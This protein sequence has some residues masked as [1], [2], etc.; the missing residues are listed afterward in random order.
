MDPSDFSLQEKAKKKFG[1]FPYEL[2]PTKDY[3][4]TLYRFYCEEQEKCE[5]FSELKVNEIKNLG[6]MI[7]F[8]N[9][10]TCIQGRKFIRDWLKN[11]N[12][13][14]E[15]NF[16]QEWVLWKRNPVE[17]VRA[18]GEIEKIY[19]QS[20]QGI[21]HLLTREQMEEKLKNIFDM[22][23]ELMKHKEE[24]VEEP[25]HPAR[26]FQY[27]LECQVQMKKLKKSLKKTNHPLA[28][29]FQDTLYG[30]YLFTLDEIFPIE[31]KKNFLNLCV[32]Y[33]FKKQLE[34]EE[35][36]KAKQNMTPTNVDPQN[37]VT[38][39]A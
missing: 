38:T 36:Q 1:V 27:R 19:E 2:A 29:T 6:D 33:A 5:Q 8:Q 18:E 34:Q 24:C 39:G 37:N 31:Y 20:Y 9:Y 23:E 21:S 32:I 25:P 12:E 22:Y 14:S 3:L 15:Q 26:F 11:T 16:E 10:H 7:G 17:N 30:K 4:F 28:S 35:E 13:W